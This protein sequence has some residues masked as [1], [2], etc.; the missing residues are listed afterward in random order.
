MNVSRASEHG[1]AIVTAAIA[2]PLGAALFFLLRL[3]E[4]IIRGPMALN[5]LLE[6]TAKATLFVLAVLGSKS[7]IWRNILFP[8]GTDPD[9]GPPTPLLFPL[10]C[11]T[12]F[13]LTENI[14]YYFSFPT[15]SIYK[16]LLYSYPIHLNTALL[17]ALG[18]LSGKPLRVA[19]S[20]IICVLYHLALNYLSFRLPEV[21]I[22]LFGVVNLFI[23]FLLYRRVLVKIIERSMQACWN[24][25]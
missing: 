2:L 15:S 16:R 8:R 25:K 4:G 17:Y 23:L 24:P 11:I 12:A 13:G 21:V 10:L 19:S 22:Y 20:F 5:A 18:F 6:E 1:S 9:F 7:R 3:V 14:L